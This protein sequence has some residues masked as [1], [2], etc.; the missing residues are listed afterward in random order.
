MKTKKCYECKTRSKGFKI[1]KMTHYHCKHHSYYDRL[2]KGEYVSPW[3]T[4]MKFSDECDKTKNNQP[5]NQ[6]VTTILV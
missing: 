5:N 4:L 6:Q 1:D 2:E 3:E